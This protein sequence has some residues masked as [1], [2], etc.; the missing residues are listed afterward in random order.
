VTANLFASIANGVLSRTPGCR[1]EGAATDPVRRQSY[2][3]AS[4]KA[5][6][7]RIHRH[8]GGSR[9]HWSAIKGAALGAF[10]R[11]YR[12]HSIALSKA[13][14]DR[15]AGVRDDVP[16]VDH[17]LHGD[18]RAVLWYMLDRYNHMTGQLY[19]TYATIA[20]ETGKSLGFVK[21][22][23]HR[24]R[25]FGFICWVRRTKTKEG[26]EG[27][28]GP[29]LEQTSNAYFFAWAEQ[30]VTEAKSTFQNLLTIA[31]RKLR[32]APKPARPTVPSDPKCAAILERLGRAID[33]RDAAM[34]SASS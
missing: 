25:R 13:R 8:G 9:K 21:A 3:E 15:R 34:S 12:A 22:S 14:S 24:L 32:S 7:W 31:T 11:L 20:S 10:D 30:L 17:R 23:L 16:H 28:A 19:P 4:P 29:Q 26:A 1:K 6:P 5:Q 33:R 2:H 18:D 27:H